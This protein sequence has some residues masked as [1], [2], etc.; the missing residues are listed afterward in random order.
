M[1]TIVDK[2][3]LND[4]VELMVIEAE[5]VAKKC[6]PGQFIMIRVDEDGERIPL[7]IAE[8][9]R[10]AKTV[11]IIYQIVGYSTQLLS[12]KEIGDT[13]SDFVG[14]LGKATELSYHKRVLGIGGGVGCAP[15]F[16]QL[17]K[18]SEMGVKVDVIVGGR[19][20]EF[21]IL[22]KELTQFCENV[23]IATNDGSRGV[24]GFVTDV[25]KR[26]FDSGVV[27]DEVIA[28][29]PLVM[30][31]AV[32]E[33]TRL[34]NIKTNVSLNPIMIDGTGMCGGCRVTVGG[35]TKFACVD[36]PDFDG[37]LVDFD[38][39]LRRQQFYKKEEAHVCNLAISKEDLC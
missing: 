36:G 4:T 28:I 6:E 33:M 34:Y 13:V 3:K 35:E 37:F 2:R 24:Q 20:E 22:E 12:Q 11:T 5:Y 39:L 10:E 18:L 29:G 31:K 8:Y 17:K 19:S 32:V 16:P 14:P 15:L 23:H 26:L 21:I 1:Y 38:E 30:M 27:Y 25:A 9:D 7:T